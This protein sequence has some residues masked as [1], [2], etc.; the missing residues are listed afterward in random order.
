MT[1]NPCPLCGQV[2]LMRHYEYYSG[3]HTIRLTCFCGISFQTT[4]K[5]TRAAAELAV[6]ETWNLR[7][8]NSLRPGGTR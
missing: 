5:R 8:L 6:H 7:H 3:A 1:I 2:P 4:T